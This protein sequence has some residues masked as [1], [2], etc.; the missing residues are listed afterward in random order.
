LGLL[1]RTQLR[2]GLEAAGGLEKFSY[3]KSKQG[4]Q[5]AS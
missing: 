1:P 4:S 5:E 3:G 2:L